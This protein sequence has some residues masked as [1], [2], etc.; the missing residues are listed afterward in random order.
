MT[1]VTCSRQP[2]HKLVY[3]RA[4]T[5]SRHTVSVMMT[6]SRNRSLTRV[7]AEADAAMQAHPEQQRGAVARAHAGARQPASVGL[8]PERYAGHSLRT[9]LATS[10]AAG[11]ASERVI[12][13]QTGHHSADM[14]RRYIRE[15]NLFTS[16]AASLAGL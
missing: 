3:R 2:V 13:A 9:G 10:A 7:V 6:F 8:D 5:G 16:N 1:I 15:A 11:G 4:S 12:M 14:V